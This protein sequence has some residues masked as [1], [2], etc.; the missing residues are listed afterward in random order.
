[1]SQRDEDTRGSVGAVDANTYQAAILNKL[2][3]RGFRIEYEEGA[4]RTLQSR[5]NAA[6]AAANQS[7]KSAQK[8]KKVYI[9]ESLNLLK[10]SATQS[11]SKRNGSVHGG[12]ESS[13]GGSD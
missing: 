11:F 1:M 7:K 8:K 6:I 5:Q 3:P 4:I 9:F 12:G 13:I 2:L 10:K